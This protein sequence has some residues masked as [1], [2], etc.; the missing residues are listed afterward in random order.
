MN[1]K[2]H[3]RLARS[4]AAGLRCVGVRERVGGCVLVLFCRPCGGVKIFVSFTSVCL[5]DVQA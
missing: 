1:F 4:L 5:E 2:D 3:S